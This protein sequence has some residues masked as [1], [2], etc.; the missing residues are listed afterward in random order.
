MI[1]RLTR[2]AWIF[3]LSCWLASCGGPTVPSNTAL[4]GTV[5]R[6]PIQ[7]VCRID[8]PCDAPFSA[9]FSVQ[10]DNRIVTTFRSDAEGSFDVPL[11]P[12]DYVVIPGDDAP[13]ISPGA[14]T[15]AVTVGSNGPT[16]IVLHFDTG[17]R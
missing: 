13:I 1:Q 4:T 16:T 11:S 9:T 2:S 3:G 8:V 6:G 10:R 15:K 7:P 17:I 5:V 12:G 14:Q